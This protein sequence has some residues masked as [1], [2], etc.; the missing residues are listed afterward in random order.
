MLVTAAGYC[1]KPSASGLSNCTYVG[2][3]CE[4]INHF[5]FFMFFGRFRCN[6]SPGGRL[7]P[8]AAIDEQTGDFL[9]LLVCFLPAANT[10]LSGD[11]AQRRGGRQMVPL[12]Y[13][14]DKNTIEKTQSLLYFHL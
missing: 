8:A 3:V 13:K 4:A 14:D 5:I 10:Q 7:K 1:N 12:E 11:P 9:G 6:K 2:H